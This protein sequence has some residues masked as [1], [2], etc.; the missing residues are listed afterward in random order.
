MPKDENVKAIALAAQF[1]AK[2][3]EGYLELYDKGVLH[4]GF[5]N[6]QRGVKGLREHFEQLL[7]GFPDLRIDSQH[8]F[9]D[10]ER[11]A[12][13]FT[14]YGTHKG[15][16]MGYAATKKFMIVPGVRLHLFER[17]KCVE[18]WQIMD[19]IRFL[20]GIGALPSLPKLRPAAQ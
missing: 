17:G 8:I 1:S 7:R 15:E 20:V 4:H 11:V 12:H 16:C 6:V 9:G 19:N 13:R 18:V 5:G 2:D 10:G 3:L 14:F